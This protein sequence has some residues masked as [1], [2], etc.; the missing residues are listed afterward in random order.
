MKRILTLL[1]LATL[2]G[3]AVVPYDGAYYSPDPYGTVYAAPPAYAPAYVGPPVYFGFDYRSG[4]G[5]YRPHP[6]PR[7]GF[8]ASH[9]GFR[10]GHP[11][12]SRP[13]GPR[14]GG[15]GGPHRR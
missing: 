12:R 6:H 10:G 1:A 5:H 2:G 13:G 4:G 15:H 14:G 7:P 3:C 8:R 9:P 11:G